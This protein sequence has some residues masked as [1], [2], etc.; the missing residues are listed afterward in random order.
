MSALAGTRLAKSQ[1]IHTSILIDVCYSQI[2]KNSFI[3]VLFSFNYF[4][5]ESFTTEF[6]DNKIYTFWQIPHKY[7]YRCIA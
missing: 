2:Y 7:L 1:T 5:R 4:C 3:Y 6:S